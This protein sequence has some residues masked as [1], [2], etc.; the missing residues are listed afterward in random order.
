MRINPGLCCSL[1]AMASFASTSQAPN[2]PKQV[3][4][5]FRFQEKVVTLHEPVVLLFEVHNGLKQPITLTVGSLTRQFYDLTLT[6]P[7]GQA[8]HKDPFNGQIDIVTVGSGKITVEP[9]ADYKEPL[10]MNQWFPFE[11]QGT[12]SLTS[13]LTSDIETADGSFQAESQTAQLLINARDPVRLNK[14]C[15]DLE[16]QAEM[17]TTVEAA[18]FPA[19]AL[20]YVNDPIAVSYLARLLSAHT[21]AYAKAVPGLERIGNDDAVEVLLSALNEN[22]GDTA[23]LATRSLARMQNRIANPRLKETVQKAA[24]HSSER[25]RNEFIKTQIAYLD[26]RSP[27]LQQTAIQNLMKVEDGLKQAEPALQ[28]LA[29][30][31]NQPADV[32]AAAKD[33]LQKLHPPQR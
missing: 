26:Y 19:L 10:V 14:I 13:K 5:H 29:N 16:Q 27:T 15:A 2:V 22:W 6:T 25:S 20:S 17:A 21:L 8:L 23:E 1:L 31:P 7:N 30:N 12:Y 32:R 9:G 3:D 33:A 24:Q 28:R 11:G 4:V 18:Q